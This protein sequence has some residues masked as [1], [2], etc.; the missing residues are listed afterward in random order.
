MAT[1]L[2]TFFFWDAVSQVAFLS[3]L[4]T[5]PKNVLT[6]N[7]EALFPERPRNRLWP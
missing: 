3:Y 2:N 5:E 7:K 4:V 1:P 6:L